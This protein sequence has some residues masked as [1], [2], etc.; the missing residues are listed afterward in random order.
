MSTGLA[1]PRRAASPR[2]DRL[3]ASLGRLRAGLAWPLAALACGVLAAGALFVSLQIALSGTIVFLL[4]AVYTWRPAWGV[5]GLVGFWLIAPAV[6][7]FVASQFGFIDSDPLSLAPF[8]ATAVVA[9]LALN[10]LKLPRRVSRLLLFAGGGFALGL[11][12]GLVASPPAAVF[13]LLAYVGGVSAA[14]IGYREG[15]AGRHAALR[16][17]LF[18]ALP[19]IAVYAIAQNLLGPTSW[20]QQWLDTVDISSIGVPG[21]KDKVRV[22]G[23][24]NAPGVL[25]GILC[26]GL[27]WHLANRRG[28]PL[29]LVPVA[30]LGTALAFTFVRAAWVA[31]VVAALVHLVVTNGRSGARIAFTVA[32]TILLVTALASVNPTANALVNRGDSLGNLE[33][34]ESARVR[35]ATPSTLA[36]D[37]VSSPLGHGLGTAGEANRLGGSQGL[38]NSDNAYLALLY[39]SG[40]L[41]L[42]FV[43]VPVFVIL[44]VAWRGARRPAPGRDVRAWY[45]TALV[46]CLVF[47]FTGDHLYGAVAVVFWFI[48]GAVL[49][50][51]ARSTPSRMAGAQ[52]ARALT[53]TT[54]ERT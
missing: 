26:I 29:A 15:A 4:A 28:N 23:T 21:Q 31:L 44:G 12:I 32:T 45:L 13:A 52:G 27:L 3:L 35:V 43:L 48:G 25:G 20:D 49:G 19:F 33:Q 5:A 39:Q 38:R 1:L 34:D 40:P 9:G 46:F 53:A 30:L 7:R 11:P 18:V 16:G 50:D 54:T 51:A 36:A 22:F 17:L 47:D 2:R 42:G 10:E 6:R 14:V 37:A 41:G 8:V 24:L